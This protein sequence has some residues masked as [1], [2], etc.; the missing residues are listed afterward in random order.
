MSFGVPRFTD[1]FEW[2]I[3]RECSKQGYFVIGG[4]EKLWKYF[5]IPS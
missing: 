3:I 5:K 4:K 2:E 1:K